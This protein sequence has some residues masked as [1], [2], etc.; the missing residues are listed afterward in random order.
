MH[1]GGTASIARRNRARLGAGLALMAL[2]ALVAAV[3]YTDI[4]HRQAV[5][6]VARPVEQGRVLQDA[7]LTVVRVSADPGLRPVAAALRSTI[8]GMVAAERLVPGTLLSRAELITGPALP[9]GQA[10]IG[11]VLKPGQYPIGLRIGGR[12]ELSVTPPQAS[13]APTP[14]ANS[15]DA[16]APLDAIVTALDK[17]AD[18]TGAITV[19]LQVDAAA[20]GALAQAGAASRLDLVVIAP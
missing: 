9:A 7:D 2:T 6:A 20:A 19:S 11:A 16:S 10:V 3:L 18:S 17:S 13:S 4:G 14:T 8:T 12:V 15:S 5:L 1:P